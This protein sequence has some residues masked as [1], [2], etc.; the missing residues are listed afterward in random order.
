ME[1]SRLA[2]AFQYS[3]I[4]GGIV[5]VGVE[6][7]LIWVVLLAILTNA[8]TLVY[9]STII[10][11][12]ARYLGPSRFFVTTVLLQSKQKSQI[13]WHFAYVPQKA[14]NCRWL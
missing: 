8:M 5:G 11:Q 1:L 2:F 7:L 6:A 3:L 14:H 12:G 13:R 4:F 9:C 10:P